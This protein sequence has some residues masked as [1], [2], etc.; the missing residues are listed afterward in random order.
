MPFC[1]VKTTRF[2][3]LKMQLHWNF[4]SSKNDSSLFAM[5]KSFKEASKQFGDWKCFDHAL[6]DMMEFSVLSHQAW[7]NSPEKSAI[8]EV[9]LWWFSLVNNFTWMDKV[10]TPIQSCKFVC[11]FLWR[12]K[13]GSF[14]FVWIGA[15][16]FRGCEPGTEIIRLRVYSFEWKRV[17]KPLLELNYKKW[18]HFWIWSC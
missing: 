1:S 8:W 3:P 10:K 12:R 18:D 17:E 6:L 7:K 4:L 5:V 14:K 2:F 16:Y 11:R 9:S 13:N 15:C